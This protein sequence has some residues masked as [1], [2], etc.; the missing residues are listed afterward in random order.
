M[1]LWSEVNQRWHE[2]G[3]PPVEYV[4]RILPLAA[5]QPSKFGKEYVDDRTLHLTEHIGKWKA[6]GRNMDYAPIVVDEHGTIVGGNHRHAARLI[7][8]LGRIDVLVPAKG[9]LMVQVEEE[10]D[11]GPMLEADENPFAKK[12]NEL[13]VAKDES[14]AAK[15]ESTGAKDESATRNVAAKP[16]QKKIRTIRQM[17]FRWADVEID[18][19]E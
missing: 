6:S 10:T 5:I 16:V 14:N 2:E 9:K 11:A 8:G 4:L 12:G 17:E 7:A 3:R 15:S 13:T 19:L 18:S 1:I